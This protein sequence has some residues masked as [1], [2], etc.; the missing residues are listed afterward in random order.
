MRFKTTV[1]SV[2]LFA[3]AGGSGWYL[4][5]DPANLATTPWDQPR[6]TLTSEAADAPPAAEHETADNVTVAALPEDHDGA[7]PLSSVLATS[8]ADSLL[9]QPYRYGEEGRHLTVSSGDTLMGLLTAADIPRREAYEVIEA[10]GDV[11]DPRRLREGQDITVTFAHQGTESSFTALTLAPDVETR[12]HVA[13]A[14]EGFDASKELRQFE[15]QSFAAS[16]TIRSSLYN[17]TN[18]A[19]VPDPILLELIRAYSYTL[20]FQR[21]IKVGDSFEVLF[22][23]EFDEDGNYARTGDVKY[24]SLTVSGRDIPIYSFETDEG[25]DYFTRDGKS[26]RRLLMRTPI[27]GARVS[28]SFGMRQHPIL[29]YSRMHPGVDFAAP[30]GTPIYAAGNGTVDYIDWKGGYGKFIRL[31]H[32]GGIQT[33]YAHMQSFKSGL[34]RGDRVNQGDVIGYVGTTGQSTGP[35]LHYEVRENGD[36][37]DP[38]S[39]DLPTG[40][41]LTGGELDAFKEYVETIDDM[42]EDLAPDAQVA[43]TLPQ[44]AE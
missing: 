22:D 25:T 28:S 5:A 26:I 4:T 41:E 35:H 24:A 2:L 13:R 3:F 36:Q 29:G 31:Q 11:F 34:S 15:A 19:G 39:V 10:L 7:D 8:V 32:N 40:I 23:R 18:G 30:P 12:V 38:M 20:D 33:A 42:F 9:E 44:V 6:W 43:Q 14:D 27:D 17:A 21:D 1:Y 16:G 37:I